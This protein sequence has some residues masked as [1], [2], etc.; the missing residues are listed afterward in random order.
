MKE[1]EKVKR[2]SVGSTFFILAIVIGVLTYERPENLYATNA[3][4]ALKNLTS[5][6]Y[7]ISINEI[8][9]PEI[10]LVDIRTPYEFEKGHLENAI[11][12]PAPEVLKEENKTLF[13]DWKESKKVA[14][15]YG[16]DIEEANL[17]FLLLYQLGYDNLKLVNAENRFLQNQLITNSPDV[18]RSNADIRAFIDES[19]K[20]SK[21]RVVEKEIVPVP[22]KIIPVK[23]K[24]KRPVEG[25]C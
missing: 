15:L 19:I 8:K 18:E 1:L 12:I 24:K 16:K 20:N 14:A 22:R 4:N 25:G 5:T 13:T 9:Q 2:I 17:P 6:N 11:N 23:K 10:V 21:Q 3:E 7:I